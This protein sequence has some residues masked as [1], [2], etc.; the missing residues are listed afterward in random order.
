MNK[1]P[2][3]DML[4]FRSHSEFQVGH[5]IHESRMLHVEEHKGGTLK[6]TIVVFGFLGRQVEG[7]K[8]DGEQCRKR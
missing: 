1:L 6:K 3:V 5:Y 7:Q 2:V 8:A 4:L